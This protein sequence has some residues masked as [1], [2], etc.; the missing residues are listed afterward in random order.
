MLFSSPV[1][2]SFFL[3]VS[4]AAYY[5]LP[6]RSFTLLIL[7]LAFYAWGEPVVAW[8]LVAVI[9]VNFAIGLFIDAS[10]DARRRWWL[11]IGIAAN[12]LVLTAFKYSTFLV[13]NANTALSLA[14]LPLL[15]IPHLPL[16]LGVSFFTFQAIS[17]L[18]DIHRGD[19]RAERNLIRMGV[20]KAFYP[21]LI[22]GPIVRYQEIAVELRDRKTTIDDFSL[23]MERFIVG[24]GKKLLIADPLSKAVD[25]IFATSPDL[26]TSPVAWIGLLS[27]GLQIYFDFS[28]YSD[29]A[30]GLARMFGF[31][32]PE[33]FNLP[34]D[35]KS[36]QEFW[37][38]WHM[39]L[40]RW[41]RDYLYI[42]LGGNRHGSFRTSV[43]LWIVFAT[44]GL[45]HGASWNFLI[46]GLW[47]GALLTLER[48]A[49]GRTIESLPQILR[50]VYALLAILLGWV[51][52]R[53]PSFEHATGYFEA[54]FT[55]G[56][57]GGIDPILRVYSPALL[58]ALTAGLFFSFSCA[59]WLS[60]LVGYRPTA[61]SIE[62]NN[63]I[64]YAARVVS[65]MVIGTVA[66][67]ASAANTLQSFL[68]FRF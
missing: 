23:G 62:L 48:T 46:W 29:M 65:I 14:G 63:R 38:R 28:G 3:P 34:Y 59:G 54:L 15:P 4:I 22:A 25:T 55:G 61:L 41:F 35:S 24:L 57:A 36:V 27:F 17:Y 6:H 2:L 42:P 52:F 7:S 53:S 20:F 58:I 43:N 56:F 18:V 40:S 64:R 67:G 47:H 16:P 68:Y 32:F 26:L 60:K 31:H 19:V 30:I 21:Q 39:T 49:F 8:L 44:T 50:R 10:A 33:N 1:F 11:I 13:G 5:L 12:I 51:W 9:A 45:W 37:R 66:F